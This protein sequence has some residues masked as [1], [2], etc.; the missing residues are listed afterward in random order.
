MRAFSKI[1]RKTLGLEIVKRA[2]EISSKL[3]KVRHRT[4]K[5][6]GPPPKWKK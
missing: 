4:L 6:G 1:S 3:Q 5:K 2:V